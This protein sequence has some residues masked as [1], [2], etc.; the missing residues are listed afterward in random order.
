MASVDRGFE[1]GHQAVIAVDRRG[2]ERQQRAAVLQDA[3]DGVQAQFRSCRH[4]R[5]RPSGACRPSTARCG[6]ACP[7]RCRSKIGL[8]MNVTVL[9]CRLATFL[10]MY[11]Y[12]MNWSAICQQVGELHVDFAL[13]GGRD[14]VV[15]GFD[16]DAELHASRRPSRRGRRRACRRAR[17]GSSPPCSRSCGRGCAPGFGCGWCSRPLPTSRSRTSLPRCVLD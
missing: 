7:S 3:A 8:G 13:A 11:L 17:P 6:C 16:H 15:M 14:F 5:R 9:P 4:S 2:R 10:M 12:H 1:A